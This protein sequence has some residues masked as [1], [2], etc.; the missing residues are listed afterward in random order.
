MVTLSFETAGSVGST[1]NETPTQVIEVNEGNGGH[2]FPA[3]TV[4]D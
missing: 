3:L 4:P 2:E 1:R